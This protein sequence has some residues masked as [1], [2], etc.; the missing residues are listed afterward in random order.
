MIIART[1]SLAV[2]GYDTALERVRYASS[3]VSECC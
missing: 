3:I 2:E 1:D